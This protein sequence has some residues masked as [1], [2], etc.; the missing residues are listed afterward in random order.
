[1]KVRKREI[2]DAEQWFPWKKVSWVTG[3]DSNKWCGCAV[4][5]GPGDK[6]HIHSEMFVCELLTP[7][8]LVVINPKGKKC[9]VKPNIFDDIYDKI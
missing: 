3:A 5:G 2:F 8:D 4:A 9:L 1:M 7:G 6:P